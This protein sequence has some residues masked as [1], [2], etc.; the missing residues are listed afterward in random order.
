MSVRSLNNFFHGGL[1]DF[2]VKEQ[3]FFRQVLVNPYK[4]LIRGGGWISHIILYMQNF[5]E[6]SQFI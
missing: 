2:F 1:L 6:V 4:T 3:Q 5:V